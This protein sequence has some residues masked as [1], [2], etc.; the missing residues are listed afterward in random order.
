MF[1]RAGRK[2]VDECSKVCC[3]VQG[4]KR[5]NRS[6]SIAS[7][8][9]LNGLNVCHAPR[10]FSTALKVGPTKTETAEAFASIPTQQP[11]PEFASGTTVNLKEAKKF[12][13]VADLWWDTERGPFAALHSMSPI[14][15][16]FIRS[17][18]CA[19]FGLRTDQLEPFSGLTMLD[20]G[21]GGGLLCEPLARMGAE[22][23]GVDAVAH[24]IQVASAHA[25]RDPVISR[26]VTYRTAAAETLVE[27]GVQ[28]DVV[29]S[30]EVIEHVDDVE[31]FVASLAALTKPGGAVVL[32][33]LNRT[34]TSYALAVLA[35][36]ELLRW[37][38]RGTHEW[39]K[40]VMP[41]EMAMLTHRAGLEMQTLT[42]MVYNPITTRW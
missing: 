31:G 1:V 42:G 30:L 40:F 18:V 27:E 28:F 24:S 14:R 12:Q 17:S 32:S 15:C 25:Q 39:G 26:R 37:V 20:V 21:C 41:E 19:H 6:E 29:L 3:R 4:L 22:V 5:L 38:P 23:T 33:T 10:A 7:N 34:P 16:Q 13:E 2:L 11:E 35:A 9:P 8:F 36:E